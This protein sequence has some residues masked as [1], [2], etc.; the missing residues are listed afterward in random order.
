MAIYLVNCTQY[1]TNKL[2]P[3]KDL[4]AISGG[5]FLQLHLPV[6]MILEM[7]ANVHVIV[8]AVVQPDPAVPV[9]GRNRL[10]QR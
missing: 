5:L 4:I 10:I 2:N 9:R 8:V 1:Q 6:L 3:K 7:T